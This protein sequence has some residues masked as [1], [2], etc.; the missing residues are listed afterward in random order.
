[1]KINAHGD[2]SEVVAIRSSCRPGGLSQSDKN[3][4]AS[5]LQFDSVS[6]SEEDVVAG[7]PRHVRQ[8]FLED[9]SASP[10][11]WPRLTSSVL[12]T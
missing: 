7:A 9:D 8:G 4:D 3:L 11:K 6:H 2:G 1:M 5:S 12:T 10:W